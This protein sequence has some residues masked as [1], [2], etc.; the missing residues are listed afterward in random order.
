MSVIPPSND[1]RPSAAALGV[2][3]GSDPAILHLLH[4]AR[5]GVA[6][7]EA[8][9]AAALEVPGRALRRSLR[10]LAERI[11]RGEAPAMATPPAEGDTAT[12]GSAAPVEARERFLATVVA[13]SDGVVGSVG[14]FLAAHEAVRDLRRQLARVVF[15]SLALVMLAV[16]VGTFV[17]LFPRAALQEV[18][19]EFALELSAGI[20]I[21]ETVCIVALV[22]TALVCLSI[23]AAYWMRRSPWFGGF[24]EALIHRVPLL[25]RALAI[26]DLAE[27]SDGMARMLAAERTYPDAMERVQGITASVSLQ[28]WLAAARSAVSQGASLDDVLSRMPARASLL[29]ALVSSSGPAPERPAVAWRIAADSLLRDA[30][31]QTARAVFILPPFAAIFAGGLAWGVLTL[32][33][34]RLSVLVGLISGLA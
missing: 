3:A 2:D 16:I 30:K 24:A 17:M 26:I 32:A 10:A 34:S 29:A 5:S 11:R 12:A 15:F 7:P 8:V 1:G 31:R 19:E 9:E 27:M 14:E 18:I 20:V 22:V 28:R 4:L 23:L 21:A 25:G 6:V 33:L 13:G